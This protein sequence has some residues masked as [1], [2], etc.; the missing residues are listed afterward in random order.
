MA[1][2]DTVL[3]DHFKHVDGLGE[4]KSAHRSMLS[5]DLG[6]RG[7]C[8]RSTKICVACR[9]LPMASGGNNANVNN[10]A[11]AYLDR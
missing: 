11:H 10:I 5:S 7:R 1:M 3:A 8:W 6:P 2:C 4:A 9:H